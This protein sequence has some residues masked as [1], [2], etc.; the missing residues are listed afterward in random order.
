VHRVGPPRKSYSGAGGPQGTA[1]PRGQSPEAA[2]LVSPTVATAC[3]DNRELKHPRRRSEPNGTWARSVETRRS[4]A[5]QIK[6]AKGSTNPRS[7]GGRQRCVRPS[8]ENQPAGPVRCREAKPA[9]NDPPGG[10][11]NSK[12]K[13]RRREAS[14]KPQGRRSSRWVPAGQKTPKRYSRRVGNPGDGTARPVNAAGTHERAKPHESRPG[15]ACQ[16]WR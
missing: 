12:E 5:D 8:R 2:R 16:S 1:C 13:N 4:P 11:C 3:R 14:R 7:V 10:A 9:T 6:A 15:R